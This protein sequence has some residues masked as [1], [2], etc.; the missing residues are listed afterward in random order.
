[1]IDFCLKLSEKYFSKFTNTESFI[2][3][4]A[5][6][7][8][9]H[10]I[11][12]SFVYACFLFVCICLCFSLKINK[13]QKIIILNCIGNRLYKINLMVDVLFTPGMRTDE[14]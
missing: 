13:L 1:M 8:E 4:H 5:Y 3:N 2:K 9:R 6:T 7:N 12:L 14:K 11:Y 10:L